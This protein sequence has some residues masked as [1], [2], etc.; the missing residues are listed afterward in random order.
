MD[1]SSATVSRSRRTQRLK[2]LGLALGIAAILVCGLVLISQLGGDEPVPSKGGGEPARAGSLTGIPQ[3][4][5]VLGNP[6]APVTLIEFADLQCP[7]CAQVATKGAL[8]TVIDRYVRT[9]KVKV[10][11]NLLNFLGPDSGRAAQVAAATSEQNKMW[12]F[13]DAFF[14]RQKQENSGYVTNA[15]LSSLTSDIPGLDAGKALSQS[16]GAKAKSAVAVWNANG[17][18]AHVQ[19]TPAFF[20]QR[21]DGA[22]KQIEV[23]L[24]NVGTFSTPLDDALAG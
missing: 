7:Y 19:G 11:L 3:N 1:P 21:G 14:A 23:K 13:T 24:D 10:E 8:P 15:F 17:K 20:V 5:N 2:L 6:N 12:Q 22:A 4:G 16:Q 9:G 18:A